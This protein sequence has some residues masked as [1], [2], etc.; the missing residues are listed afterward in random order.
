MQQWPHKLDHIGIRVSDLQ[1]A[2]GFYTA[3]LAP[4]GISLLGQSDQHAAFGIGEMPYL[5]IRQL[6]LSQFTRPSPVHVAFVAEMR[7]QVDEFYAAALSAGGSDNGAPGM[8]PEYHPNYYGAFVL[9]ADGH[10]I[11]VVKHA[12]E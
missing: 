12:A 5:S 9:D 3:A 2:I 7:Q 11:E 6:D 1:V 8:R 4:V 10:N